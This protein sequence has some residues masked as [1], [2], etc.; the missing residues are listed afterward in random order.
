[1]HDEDG[2]FL[3]D[4]KLYSAYALLSVKSPLLATRRLGI[5]AC[6]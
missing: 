1:M 2:E 4:S 3:A 5:L 6:R